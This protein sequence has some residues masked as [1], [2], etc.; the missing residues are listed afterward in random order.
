MTYKDFLEN[1]AT[2]FIKWTNGNLNMRIE[3]RKV[4]T[5]E[6]EPGIEIS[7]ELFSLSFFQDKSGV[8][9]GDLTGVHDFKDARIRDFPNLS[10]EDVFKDLETYIK[11]EYG[12]RVA[13][14]FKKLVNGRWLS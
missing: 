8:V 9:I 7:E 3:S 6:G 1:S 2:P 13:L 5:S 14:N 11:E 4:I 10:D 12:D